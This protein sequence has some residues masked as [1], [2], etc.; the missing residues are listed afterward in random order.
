MKKVLGIVLALL[1]TLSCVLLVACNAKATELKIVNAPE[2]VNRGATIDY[3][4]ISVVATFEDGT[5]K[6]LALTEKG[7][8]YK[9]IDT[10]TT[11]AKTL[12][13]SYGGKTAQ[14]TITVVEGTVNIEDVVVTEFNNTDGYNEYLEAKKEQ[15]EKELEFFNRNE[16]YKVGTANGYRFLPVVTAIDE[17]DEEIT[18]ED[19]ITTYKLYIQEDA[20]FVEVT[21][22]SIETYL[23]NVENN[24]YYF[25]NAAEHETFKLEVTLSDAYE[26]LVPTMKTTVEQTFEVVSGYNVYDALGLSVLDN[27]NIKSWASKKEHKF[28]WDNGK[29]LS[30]FTD[31]EQVIIHENITIKPS[32]L[33]A[34]YFWKV[35]DPATKE[36]SVSY[37]DALSRV[38]E[39]LEG[40]LAGSLK[41]VWLGEEWEQGSDVHQR[42]LYVTDAIG[43]SGNYLKIDY[44]SNLNTNGNNGLYIVHDFNQKANEKNDYP[45]SHYS[46]IAYR[47]EGVDYSKVKGNRT[48]ENVYFVGQTSKTENDSTPA[49]LMMVSSNIA[50]LKINN[51]IGAKWFCNATLDGLAEGTVAIDGCKFYDSFSQMIYSYGHK[52]I[53]VKNSEMKRAGGPIIIMQT[54]TGDGA[55]DTRPTQFTVDSMANMESW[56]SGAEMWFRIN[57]AGSESVVPQMLQL[58]TLSDHFG[59]GTHYSVDGKANLIA[60]VIPEPGKVMTNQYAT[61]GTVTIGGEQY[62]MDA[63]VF[64][65]LINLSATAGQGATLAQQTLEAVGSSLEQD[66]QT[67]LGGLKVG[68]ETLQEMTKDLWKAPIYKCGGAYAYTDYNEQGQPRLNSLQAIV[69]GITVAQSPMP[70]SMYEGILAVI[71]TLQSNIEQ[72]EAAGDPYQNLASLKQLKAGWDALKIAID[73]IASVQVND[74]NTLWTA[75]QLSFWVNP[76]AMG[77]SGNK[78]FMVLIGEGKAA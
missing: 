46:L 16:L 73:P 51:T 2:T 38:N 69:N 20:S 21:G 63:P 42:G 3:S 45:E 44:V 7:V 36:G 13:A 29:K 78:H 59:T 43:L 48:V 32:D 11:G 55:G 72:L 65:A 52:A 37:A 4:K 74:W 39:K 28:A 35:G 12:E 30:E 19:V 77:S 53:D 58:A 24:V 67:A 8:S 76:A 26:L 9:A 17:N 75:G 70:M 5:T 40:Y 27:R 10:S 54:R 66:Q 60:I 57:M 47:H 33:P 25:T 22:D 31:V 64:N 50:D 49:G 23:S 61:P 1:L 15:S 56:V 6:T 18:L 34:N 68:F 62:G 41:E 71:S 14:T